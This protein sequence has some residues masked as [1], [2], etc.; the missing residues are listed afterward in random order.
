MRKYLEMKEIYRIDFCK[1]FNSM[2]RDQH[3]AKFSRMNDGNSFF[4]NNSSN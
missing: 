4:Y 2:S 3:K 1:E